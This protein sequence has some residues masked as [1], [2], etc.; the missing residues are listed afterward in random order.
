MEA[1]FSKMEGFMVVC[2]DGSKASLSVR[3]SRC[4]AVSLVRWFREIKAAGEA[5]E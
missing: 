5:L 1:K 4:G 3:R 2:E